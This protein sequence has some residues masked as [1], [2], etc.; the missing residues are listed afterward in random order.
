[1][2]AVHYTQHPWMC[3]VPLLG[4]YFLGHNPSKLHSWASSGCN[5]IWRSSRQSIG[6]AHTLLDAGHLLKSDYASVGSD[7]VAQC[8]SLFD[9]LVKNQGRYSQILILDLEQWYRK[10]KKST[11]SNNCKW[12]G[13]LKW[14]YL[15]IKIE[16]IAAQEVLLRVVANLNRGDVNVWNL[17]FEIRLDGV[18]ASISGVTLRILRWVSNWYSGTL[19]HPVVHHHWRGGRGPSDMRIERN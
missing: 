1:M 15:F 12:R 8:P 7:I 10:P 14:T 4:R 9:H 18:D 17:L 13:H 3:T 11:W 16:K 2:M 5:R 6:A 19:Y